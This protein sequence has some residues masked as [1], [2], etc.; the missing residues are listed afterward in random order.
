MAALRTQK[1]VTRSQN[2]PESNLISPMPPAGDTGPQ[3]T[4]GRP[5]A[6]AVLY[7]KYRE[8]V[9]QHMKRLPG[10]FTRFTGLFARLIWAPTW[11]CRWSARELP[12]HSRLCRQITAK[13]PELITRCQ[14][15]AAH[16]LAETLESGHA[17]H[18]FTCFLG[19]RNFWLPIILRGCLIGLA[20]VQALALPATGTPVRPQPLRAARVPAAK[21]GARTSRQGLRETKLVSRSEFCEAA[22]LLQ[23][24]VHH[25]ETS[26]LADLRKSDLTRA[27]QAL[28]ELQ[29]VARRLRGELNGLVPAFSKTGPVLQSEKHWEQTVRAALARIHASYSHPL[30]L[31]QCAEQLGLNAAYLSALF[32]RSVG[33]PFKTYLTDLRIEKARELLSEPARSV[34]EVAYAVGYA[35]ENRF[36]IAFKRVTGLPPHFWRETLRM[37]PQPPATCS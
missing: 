7:E 24:V 20:F 13:G 11:P 35:S 23:L 17:G 34:S 29:T 6:D 31:K 33:V 1:S 10:L 22:R 19:V 5:G 30:T 25:I 18:Q 16:H 12:T 3:G 9:R 21:P 27:Q 15:C 4:T 26:A 2:H 32:S 14:D 28:V 8:L 37:P 36:R